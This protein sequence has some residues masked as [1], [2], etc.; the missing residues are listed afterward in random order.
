MKKQIIAALIAL[1]ASVTS[2]YAAINRDWQLTLRATE[3]M[4]QSPVH[5][6]MMPGQAHMGSKLIPDVSLRY[7]FSPHWALDFMPGFAKLETSWEHHGQ[8]RALGRVKAFSPVLTLEYQFRPQQNLSPYIGAGPA[9]IH[10][11]D[12]DT[13]AGSMVKYQDQWGWALQAGM[14]YQMTSRL[15]LNLDIKRVAARAE[16]KNHQGPI[17]IPASGRFTL[18]MVGVGLGYRF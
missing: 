11:F 14:D 1:M 17:T 10:F 6:S 7:Y 15:K 3:I 13:P 16:I 12:S 5:S 2:S 18:W 9:Y 4:A 8:R